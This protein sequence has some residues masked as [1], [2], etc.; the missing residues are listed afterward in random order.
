MAM[1]RAYSF[2][3]VLPEG[4]D[5]I[6]LPFLCDLECEDAQGLLLSDRPVMLRLGWCDASLWVRLEAKDEVKAGDGLSVKVGRK[7]F[8]FDLAGRQS[9]AVD[10]PWR[11]AGIDP[12]EGTEFRLNVCRTR[13]PGIRGADQLGE[14]TVRLSRRASRWSFSNPI[15]LGDTWFDTVFSFTAAAEGSARL[16]FNVW[17][18]RPLRFYLPQSFAIK[19]GE[20]RTVKLAG[21]SMDRGNLDLRICDT[22]GSMLFSRVL[23]FRV[24]EPVAVRVIRTDRAR[25]LLLL[26]TDNRVRAGDGYTVK[27]TMTDILDE[28]RT[29][30]EKSV[31]ATV[32]CGVTNEVFDVS[33]LQPGVYKAVSGVYST[34]GRLLREYVNYYAKENGRTDWSGSVLGMEDEVPVP[35]TRPVAGNGS[36]ACWGRDVALGGSGLVSSVRSQGRELLS[37]SVEVV[38]NGERIGFESTVVRRRNAGADYVL[39]ARNAPLLATLKAEFDG[40]LWFDLHWGG[41]AFGKSEVRTLDLVFPL[42]RSSLA[43]ME[44]SPNGF[45]RVF[46][47]TNSVWKVDPTKY[48]CWWFGDGRTG[49][50]LG[51]SSVR[52]THLKEVGGACEIRVGPEGAE[53]VMHLVDTP[54]VPTEEKRFGFYLEATPSHP[55]NGECALIPR[56]KVV[57]WTGQ[58]ARFFDA[59]MPGLMDEARCERFRREQ[60]EQ[61]KSVFY[62]YSVKGTS[63]FQPWWGRFGDNW[64]RFNDPSIW[65]NETMVKPT[66][67]ERVLR[68]HGNWVRTC[69]ASEGFADFKVWTINWFLS[70]PKYDVR[71]LYFDLAQPSPCNTETHG[72]VWTDDFGVRRT[73]WDVRE[74]RETNLRAYRLLKRKNP[75]GVI[76]GHSGTCRV[77]SDVFFD[78]MV[79]GEHYASAVSVKEGYYDVLNPEDMQVKY[80]SRSNEFVI[81]MLP[82]IVRGMEMG[83]KA[84]K[85]K[86]YNPLGKDEDRAIRHATAYFKIHDLLVATAVSGRR[87]G[88]Q[89]QVVEQCIAKMGPDREFKAYY[90]GDC[91]ISVDVPDRLFL[92]AWFRGLGK[93]LVIVLNDTDETVTKVI[94]VKGLSSVGRDLFG[95]GDADFSAG[96]VKT[97]LGPRESRF[98]LAEQQDN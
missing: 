48:P 90:H 26:E 55:K 37:R 85:V 24:N 7:T 33:D 1:T 43:G 95:N 20:T 22:D 17:G 41:K 3:F 38:L 52:G 51:L 2:S 25:E 31:P 84:W 47:E 6:G 14:A 40:F 8:D 28:S 79:R 78:R 89:W 27:L 12:G 82:Q 15:H 68:E 93:T 11:E 39:K 88:P 53:V 97:T 91:P 18:S 50:M 60:N 46:G 29:V 80:A 10:I 58:V 94:R 59:S 63:P 66:T 81:D 67:D 65:Y 77:P 83:G 69:L 98:W 23:K 35:W 76:F 36:F 64:T 73:R 71:N 57:L 96:E 87:D 74:L 34:D 4:E 19:A 5:A 16:V 9:F 54:F 72:C 45:F 92:Y 75:H 86:T 44:I 13:S 61:G 62:Y 32:F 56:E 49:M 70:E 21:G 42:E 30:W